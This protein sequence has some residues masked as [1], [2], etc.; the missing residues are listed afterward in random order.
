MLKDHRLE[1]ESRALQRRR[2]KEMAHAFGDFIAGVAPWDWFINPITFRDGW[3]PSECRRALTNP[4]T[5][6]ILRKKRVEEKFRVGN[7]AVYGPDPR[8]EKHRPSSRNNV[9]SGA[10]VPDAAIAFIQEYFALL[11]AAADAPIGWM[12][13]EEFGRLGGRWHCHALVTGVS[14]LL[15]KE[16]WRKAYELFGRSRIEPFDPERGAAFYAA[17]YASKALGGIH[18]G[19]T[20]AG[21]DLSTS[22]VPSKKGGAIDVVKSAD[23]PKGYFHNSM[24]RWHR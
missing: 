16:W 24:S 10:P 1:V 4:V 18:F 9:S 17:K 20:L 15:R 2:R 8:I 19:G 5:P 22:R 3:R 12:I 6:P 23:S 7:Y 14:K 11:Q 21:V 13:A